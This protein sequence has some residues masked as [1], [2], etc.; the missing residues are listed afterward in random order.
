MIATRVFEAVSPID[1]SQ[2]K[3]KYPSNPMVQSPFICPTSLPVE[4]HARI[5][6]LELYTFC[7]SLSKYI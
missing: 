3:R 7:R 4:V 2:N 1:Q 6:L 5:Y